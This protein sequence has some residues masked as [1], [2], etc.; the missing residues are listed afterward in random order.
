MRVGVMGG[1]FDPV[2]LG[3][4]LIAEE[5]RLELDL[6]RII[7]IP[8][9]Q[10]WLRA[11]E[12]LSPAADRLRM[13]EL[14][15]ASNPYFYACSSEVD[16]DGTTYTV[17]TLEEMVD[18]FDEDT[19]IF[20]IV[21]ADAL[22]E[23]HRWKEPGRV[24]ELCELAVVSRPGY[25]DFDR[26]DW[27]AR[28]PGGTSKVNVLRSPQIGFSGSDIRSRTARGESLRY[29]VPEPVA[30]YIREHHLYQPHGGSYG[31]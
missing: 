11:D 30:E 28:F 8:A 3:H 12:R 19:R 18:R 17:D 15:V 25:G 2:H 14:A 9:G 16:R 24:L 13:V 26:K 7:F 29:M 10:P 23:F 5:A 31:R 21:G 1:T 27:E 22:A 6:E 20:F 4:M